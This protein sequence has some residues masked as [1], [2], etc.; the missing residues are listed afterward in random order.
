[1]T[2]TTLT[3][4]P[5][6]YSPFAYGGDHTQ[7]GKSGFFGTFVQWDLNAKNDCFKA[8]FVF[9]VK[10]AFAFL[11]FIGI[12]TRYF[13]HGG[14]IGKIKE[15]ERYQTGLA[16]NAEARQKIVN[17]LG[18][19]AICARIPIVQLNSEDFHEYLRLRDRYF[20][21]S[22]WVVQG[23]DPAGRK[24]VSMRTADRSG[25]IHFATAHQRYRETCI[26]KNEAGSDGSQWTLTFENGPELNTLQT[27][28]VVE[29]IQKV[30]TNQ[31]EQFSV[32]PKP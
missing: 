25:N 12:G 27:A 5:I 6:Q 28:S 32:A 20:R 10:K 21:G 3:N 15:C 13:E 11:D 4:K 8:N 16:R 7:L 31:H 2:L 18:G 22:E 23:E 1:M 19:S 17:A 24:F 14:F 30:R 9:L 26:N 29:F